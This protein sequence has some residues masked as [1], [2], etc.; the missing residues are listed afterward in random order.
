[1]TLPETQSPTDPIRK[2]VTV[3]LD[4]KAAFELFT[5]GIDRWWPKHSHSL[6]ASREIDGEASVRVEP[7]IGGRVL[8]RLPDGS[9][10]PWATV[11]AW[12]PGTRLRLSWYVGRDEEEATT[13]DV[14]FTQT[15]AGT[16]VDLTHG[17]FHVF[18][19]KAPEMCAGYTNGWDTVL[20]VCYRSACESVAA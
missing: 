14:T 9:E 6:T 16:R 2:T 1:M 19:A 11:T 10:A 17:G 4:R 8:E 18:G 7:R 13:I 3:P 12:Q 5:G 20:G 15:E